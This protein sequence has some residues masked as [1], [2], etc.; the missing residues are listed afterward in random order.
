MPN[1]AYLYEAKT[2]T[3]AP[4]VAE[5]L[6]GPAATQAFAREGPLTRVFV[7]DY[8]RMGKASA[9]QKDFF[10][11]ADT[12]YISQN[13]YLFCASEGLATGVRAGID[14]PTLG[15]ALKLRPEQKIILAQTVGY[16]KK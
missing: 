7:A 10:A 15:K 13:V 8:A 6:R 12:G 3:L 11:P 14:R 4:V 9:E 16:P 1:G 2:H 5:D